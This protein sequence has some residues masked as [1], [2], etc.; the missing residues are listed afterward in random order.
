MK[1][2]VLA[3]MALCLLIALCVGIA[4]YLLDTSLVKE[5]R[6]WDKRQREEEEAAARDRDHWGI[7]DGPRG[8]L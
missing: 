1:E 3:V 4:V 8:P 6:R 7:L 5:R 2:A